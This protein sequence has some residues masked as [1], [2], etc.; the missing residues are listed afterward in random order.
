MTNLAVIFS[1][2]LLL[3]DT[4]ADA[5]IVA[6][7][8]RAHS[9]VYFRGNPSAAVELSLTEARKAKVRVFPL[10]CGTNAVIS[11]AAHYAAQVHRRR[12]FGGLEMTIDG[13]T[14]VILHDETLVL[15]RDE[16]VAGRFVNSFQQRFDFSIPVERI[17]NHNRAMRSVMPPMVSPI[18]EGVIKP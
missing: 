1:L 13:L 8:A 14:T 11:P 6:E 10:Y 3:S 5:L 15:I 9:V 4:N 12:E 17:D 7:V 2:H 18:V 16:A